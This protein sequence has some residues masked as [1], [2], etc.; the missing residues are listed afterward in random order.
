MNAKHRERERERKHINHRN[1][2]RKEEKTV[3]FAQKEAE[4][5]NGM[6]EKMKRGG[7]EKK[8]KGD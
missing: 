4:E 7:H 8:R 5:N 6:C 2:E 1:A 3:N